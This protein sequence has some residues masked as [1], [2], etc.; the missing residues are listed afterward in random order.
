MKNKKIIYLTYQTFP[1]KTANSFQ[2]ISNIRFLQKEG[3]DIH[4]YFPLR[5]K[6]SDAEIKNLQQF[7]KFQESFKVT[8]LDHKYPH[9]KIKFFKGI[10]FH[11]SH[12][13]WSKKV[14]YK[15]FRDENKSVFFTRSEW[16]AY[17]LSKLGKK[18]IFEVHQPSKLRDIILKFLKKKEN[19]KFIFL[20]EMLHKHYE[21]ISN[22]R[23]LHNATQIKLD[24]NNKNTKE[25]NLIV[26]AGNISRFNKSRGLKEF[27]S[28]FSDDFLRANYKFEII[29]GS[30]RDVVDLKS[31]ISS[32]NLEKVIQ[33]T[34]WLSQ[35][36]VFK[37]LSSASIGLLLN[38]SNNEHSLN[39]TSPI[40][41]FEYLNAKLSILA[42][43]FPSHRILP[44]SH[45]INFFK[46]GDKESFVEALKNLSQNKDL[47]ENELTAI[48]LRNR[49]KR[50]LTFIE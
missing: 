50:I 42:V 47:T 14:V 19:V 37:K 20:N 9:G 38:T 46:E 44:L 6:N 30:K 41:Y 43:D 2:S 25:K 48:S 15:Y 11:L 3:A 8:G 32:Q 13:L 40:K 7:Y 31:W 12:Y 33:V 26:F 27:I 5:D 21:P 35:D 34:E 28:W 39:Y 4:L 24:L 16:I 10:W 29:G 23:V 17:F 49:A 22:Y 1:A 45:R 36:E 18:V